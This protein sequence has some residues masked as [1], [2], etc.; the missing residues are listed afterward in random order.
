[1]YV[2]FETLHYLKIKTQGKLGYMTLKL[3]ISKAYDKVEWIFL[4]KVMRH[5]GF[6]DSLIKIIMSCMST[7]FYTVLLNGQP[8][9]NIKPTRG[10][11]QGDSLF[12]Y[13]FLLCA[14]GLQGLLKKAEV[15]GDMN[16]VSIC[17]NG[18]KVS[19]YFLLMIVSYFVEPRRRN[20][21]LSQICQQSMKEGRGKKSI[22]RKPIFSLAL[23]LFHRF[24]AISSN[25][26]GY[27]PF[28]NM[29]NIQVYRPQ[30]GE[31]RNKVSSI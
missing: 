27:W 24:R 31:L 4:E 10:L 14:F 21:K 6:A 7:V 9:G 25:S 30:W 23:I 12:L 20:A 3:D 17:L 28:G 15:Q 16:G 29:K 2:A 22:E 5:L 13:L 26:L 19:L 8:V 11:R 1:M 18:P